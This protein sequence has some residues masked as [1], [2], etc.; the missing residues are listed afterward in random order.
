MHILPSPS[1]SRMRRGPLLTLVHQ[2]HGN[3]QVLRDF[4]Q[5]AQVLVQLLLPVR[6]LA[7]AREVRPEQRGDGVD[8]LAGVGV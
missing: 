4:L 3:V 8:D 2:Q 7:A 5:S 1:S 6:Q